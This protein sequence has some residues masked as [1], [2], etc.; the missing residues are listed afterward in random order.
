MAKRFLNA[1]EERIV[2][3]VKKVMLRHKPPTG[4]K[5]VLLNAARYL[6]TGAK[7]LNAHNL[8]LLVTEDLLIDVTDEFGTTDVSSSFMNVMALSD[9]EVIKHYEHRAPMFT[10]MLLYAKKQIRRGILTSKD[11]GLDTFASYVEDYLDTDGRYY[12][13]F[14]APEHLRQALEIFWSPGSYRI[15]S[16]NWVLMRLI[17]AGYIAVASRLEHP[18]CSVVVQDA[19]KHL[20]GPDKLII[21]DLVKHADTRTLEEVLEREK[22]SMVSMYGVLL[23]GAYV[24]EISTEV[25]ESFKK[26]NKGLSLLLR[27]CTA[28][29]MP[30]GSM[31][32]AFY[33]SSM[34][35]SII[36]QWARPASSAVYCSILNA[37]AGIADSAQ[38]VTYTELAY[39]VT[40]VVAEGVKNALMALAGSEVMTLARRLLNGTDGS[41]TLAD[42][43][44]G[45]AYIASSA[46]NGNLNTTVLPSVQRAIADG[47]KM[48]LPKAFGEE[49]TCESAEKVATWQSIASATGDSMKLSNM[50]AA[51]ASLSML[52]V[53]YLSLPLIGFSEYVSK[54]LTGRTASRGREG[55]FVAPPKMSLLSGVVLIKLALNTFL[56]LTP[57][58]SNKLFSAVL[59]WSLIRL[60]LPLSLIEQPYKTAAYFNTAASAASSSRNV[61]IELDSWKCV[62]AALI[63]VPFEYLGHVLT[64]L[65]MVNGGSKVPEPWISVITG[66][67]FIVKCARIAAMF[68]PVY[69]GRKT[70]GR[71]PYSYHFE[72]MFWYDG[73]K[74]ITAPPM[75]ILID[76]AAGSQFYTTLVLASDALVSVIPD[77]VCGASVAAMNKTGAKLAALENFIY[78]T[79][80]NGDTIAK[81]AAITSM[82]RLPGSA[83]GVLEKILERHCGKDIVKDLGMDLIV[84]DFGGMREG[85]EQDEERGVPRSETALSIG[86]SRPTPLS[87]SMKNVSHH[88]SAFT[89]VSSGKTDADFAVASGLLVSSRG[90]G[91]SRGPGSMSSLHRSE[92][93]AT[94]FSSVD[95]GRSS[96]VSRTGS[97]RRGATSGAGT[98]VSTPRA[99]IRKLEADDTRFDYESRD[100]RSFGEAVQDILEYDT[101]MRSKAGSTLSLRKS[102][103]QDL[104]EVDLDGINALLQSKEIQGSIAD[105][106]GNPLGNIGK[107][108]RDLGHIYMKRGDSQ[109]SVGRASVRSTSGSPHHSKIYIGPEEQ[110][111]V[112]ELDITPADS[113]SVLTP[114]I[115]EQIRRI[116]GDDARA[117]QAQQRSLKTLRQTIPWGK[118]EKC[119]PGIRG[120]ELQYVSQP[121]F[122]SSIDEEECARG[123]TP[124]R[125]GSAMGREFAQISPVCRELERGSQ[126]KSSSTAAS[127][128]HQSATEVDAY[129]SPVRTHSGQG[130]RVSSVSPAHSRMNAAHTGSSA[131][132]LAPARHFS[133]S[134]LSHPAEVRATVSGAAARADGSSVLGTEM[135][136]GSTHRSSNAHRSSETSAPR[137]KDGRKKRMRHESAGGSSPS[138]AITRSSQ[139]LF[140]ASVGTHRSRSAGIPSSIDMEPAFCNPNTGALFSSVG[141]V[142]LRGVLSGG[143][144]GSDQPPAQHLTSVDSEALI[145]AGRY[146]QHASHWQQ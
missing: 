13:K 2:A 16:V 26:E 58:F 53:M 31:S 144:T 18:L 103:S 134:T 111:E 41:G 3:L 113:S 71:L 55:T 39:N 43:L 142:V 90:A 80:H 29:L 5:R 125:M 69:L 12:E 74:A 60:Y 21:R 86:S 114:F 81:L 42:K 138:T 101:K 128:V 52:V 133:V 118:K 19:A 68:A 8:S 96:A 72:K 104:K 121:L 22:W 45:S 132:A 124:H 85:D 49:F 51:P 15:L 28:L 56:T 88:G 14:I 95:L 11:W 66:Y 135:V 4:L 131:N 94:V 92:G 143:I 20:K 10:D 17:A 50:S 84:D 141:D 97:S 116:E 73:V 40:S 102:Q 67:V 57:H 120:E 24:N 65:H 119:D 64:N 25:S 89:V 46:L 36:D 44:R 77:M 23:L 83:C 127:P 108:L 61:R 146:A 145:P 129:R 126:R 30:I 9:E 105:L 112:D 78:T 106:S 139:Q 110:Q 93:S 115:A 33:A 32:I 48:I 117:Q 59:G 35:S 123:S 99:R 107:V 62:A 70:K 100:Y 7:P 87:P 38:A 63:S 82:E 37:T 34:I 54:W 6:S 76:A 27:T 1:T 136:S 79:L 137:R 130:T 91:L 140:A 75:L 47:I 109:N 122:S 98:I